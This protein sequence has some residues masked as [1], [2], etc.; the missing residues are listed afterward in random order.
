MNGN[1]FIK[2]LIDK[3]PYHKLDEVYDLI[4][5][6]DG[7]ISYLHGEVTYN[8]SYMLRSRM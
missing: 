6:A 4:E 7:N 2:N 3:V 1:V 8:G 5:D